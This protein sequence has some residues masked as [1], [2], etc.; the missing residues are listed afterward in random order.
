MRM[1]LVEAKMLGHC[2]KIA[3][4]VPVAA[5]LYPVLEVLH[6]GMP[7][8]DIDCSE[9]MRLFRLTKG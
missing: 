2:G 4:A 8:A 7:L 3:Q 6:D 5:L 9:T 1:G